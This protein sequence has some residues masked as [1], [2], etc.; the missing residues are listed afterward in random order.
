M[1]RTYLAPQLYK[2]TSYYFK[3]YVEKNQNIHT[4]FSYGKPIISMLS[5]ISNGDKLVIHIDDKAL[6]T[7]TTLKHIRDFIFQ[8]SHY[9]TMTEAN[10]KAFK[11]DDIMSLM[12]Y[13]F[14][15][16]KDLK[17]NYQN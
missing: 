6:L 15:K 9:N 4:L 16:L 8:Y 2:Q 14:S 3:A 12:F 13:D 17:W 5:D 10:A 7:Y 11:K 1:E